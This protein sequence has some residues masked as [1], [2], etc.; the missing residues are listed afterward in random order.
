MSAFRSVF[1]WLA[2][3]AALCAQAVPPEIPP[4]QLLQRQWT[5]A[6][7][8]PQITV[9]DIVQD[10]SGALWLATQDGVAQFDGFRFEVFRSQRE[11]ALSHNYTNALAA[12]RDG[13]VWVGSTQGLARLDARG[14]RSLTA[15]GPAA[16][17]VYRLL[18]AADGGVWVA[19]EAGLFRADAGRL[20]PVALPSG[21]GRVV[22]LAHAADGTAV[23]ALPDRLLVDPA[24]AAREIP[25]PGFDDLRSLASGAAGGDVWLWVGTGQGLLGIAADGR[26][27]RRPLKQHELETLLLD[28]HGTLWIGSDD[29]L[30]RLPAGELPQRVRISALGTGHWIRSL[31]EDRN[32]V[33]WVG[34]QVDGLFR[35]SAG[36]FRRIGAA[37][38]LTDEVVWSLYRDP[39]GG[40]WAGGSDGVYHGDLSGFRRP[41][42]AD[43]LPHP[44]VLA[45]LRDRDG[46]LWIGTRQGL[47]RMRPGAS[48]PTPV[49]GV[50]AMIYSLSQDD[51]GRI[52]IGS[53][54]GVQRIERDRLET[55]GAEHGLPTTAARTIVQMSDGRIWIG[56][57]LGAFRE[58]APDRFVAVGA[59]DGTAAHGMKMLRETRPGEVLIAVK[60][61]IARTTLAGDSITLIDE[62]AGLHAGMVMLLQPDARQRLWYATNNGIGMLP[63][64]QIDQWLGGSRRQ[65]EPRIHG[66]LGEPQPAQCNGGHDNAGVLIDD[67]WLWCPS[68]HGALVLDL[69]AAD[70]P[71]ALP[72]PVIQA[73]SGEGIAQ[74]LTA[75][76]PLRLPVGVRD[77][78]FDF[79]GLHLADPNA[80][81]HQ[82]QLLGYDDAP[83]AIGDRRSA[84]YTNL[85]P[86]EY[87][88]E[89]TAR[90][91]GSERNSAPASVSLLLPA[92][93]HE[94]RWF[95]A[96]LLLSAVGTALVLY[97]WRVHR[98]EQAHRTLADLVRQR[99]A[100]LEDANRRLLESS[101]TDPLTGLR[102]RRYLLGEISHDVAQVDRTYTTGRKDSNRDLLFLRLDLDHFEQVND[103]FDRHCGDRILAQLAQLLAEQVRECDYAIRWGGEQFLVVGRQVDRAHA[104]ALAERLVAAVRRHRF[105]TD[106]GELRCT[107]S[108]GLAVYPQL[109]R[110]PRAL[111]WQ[112]T[113][114]LADAA[115][116]IARQDGRDRWVELRLPGDDID[117]DFIDRFRDS[118]RALI[119][120]GVIVMRSRQVAEPVA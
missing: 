64:L 67:R 68:L 63:L 54:A 62:D 21:A 83:R 97:R 46:T 79:A 26:I 96:A 1:A 41:F 60:G 15:D 72:T 56:G 113:I 55:L 40:L 42:P 105:V 18:A 61:G 90:L 110:Q 73:V 77:L 118:P 48:R 115:V 82:V 13:A 117:D 24:G 27:V 14:W 57:D 103:R 86:G 10:A 87:R 23:A 17:A 81:R 43:A 102:S 92:R 9:L 38:G 89:V 116:G 66:R 6:D 2:S 85:P 76:Q 50:D 53:R 19:A 5:V 3:C 71:A 32:G 30:W 93:V 59:A 91:A 109:P 39:A 22:A 106:H 107:C 108:I 47:A 16:G 69:Q 35:L 112:D 95:Q 111:S 98:L 29:G 8:L 51:R 37:D 70:A 99:T 74:S 25:L 36:V 80:V 78:Q 11:P 84:F 94:S 120:R 49:P 88:F 34:T 58:R 101:V 100:E 31:H 33:L 28:R 119:D 45:F 52:W 20:Q 114:E 104:H 7:G 65:L 4:H 44:M 75:G 12:D